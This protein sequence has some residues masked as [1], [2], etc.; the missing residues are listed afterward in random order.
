MFLF[1]WRY[2]QNTFMY[3][4]FKNTASGER[5]I[6]RNE[7][8][9]AEQDILLDKESESVVLQ[10][11]IK[12]TTKKKAGEAHN[13]EESRAHAGGNTYSKYHTR[14]AHAGRSCSINQP[15]KTTGQSNQ[16]HFLLRTAFA[17]LKPPETDA[18]NTWGRGRE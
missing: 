8:R 18:N 9:K 14:C 17:P 6:S 5:S 7:T 11:N 4:T 13:R 2:L 15:Q 16:I 10:N 3:G 1:T 12:E